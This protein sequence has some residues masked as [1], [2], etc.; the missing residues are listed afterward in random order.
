MLLLVGL[1][2]P[3]AS[4]AGHRHNIGFMA[5]DELARWHGFGPF[6]RRFGGLYCDGVL[7][8]RRVRLLKPQTYMNESGRS[9]GE[10]VRYYGLR[11][12]HVYVLYDEIDLVPG[13]CRV[14]I[15]GGSGGH[16]G[17][18]SI[19]RHVGKD[20]WRVR[21][22]VGHPGHKDRVRRYVLQ[23]FSRAERDG[24]LPTLLDAVARNAPLLVRG[25]E[26][27][28]MSR[29]AHAVFPPPPRPS[30]PVPGEQ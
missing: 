7:D 8:G 17:I 29:V 10:A 18:R 16:N 6:R 4:Y 1:G 9:V 13:K 14:K 20:F 28:F 19:E 15:G 27:A 23:D 12:A 26:N 30:P 3:G 21:L 24:W 11:I 22:G 2:N 5:I 25:E